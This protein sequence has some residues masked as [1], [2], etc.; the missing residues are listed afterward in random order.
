MS[1]CIDYTDEDIVH[2]LMKIKD[3][4]RKTV[5]FISVSGSLLMV[6]GICTKGPIPL[7]LWCMGCLKKQRLAATFI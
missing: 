5:W 7:N 1:Q 2:A 3:Y 6:K 4:M